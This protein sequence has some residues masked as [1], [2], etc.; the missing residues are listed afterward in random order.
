MAT[1]TV[2]LICR[3]LLSILL[4]CTLVPSGVA[5]PVNVSLRFSNFD[6]DDGLSQNS[7]SSI[8]QDKYG[9]IWL[10]TQGGINRFDGYQ[11]THFDHKPDDPGSLSDS[12][13]LSLFVDGQGNLWV[14]THSGGLN[15]FDYQSQTFIQYMDNAD[16][17]HGINGNRI[18]AISQSHSDEL[19]IATFGSGL[20]R[21]DI[22]EQRFL[23]V[24]MPQGFEKIRQVND[25]VSDTQGNLWL[26]TNQYGLVRLSGDG[27]R[28]QAFVFDPQDDTSFSHKN[29]TAV[30][31]D[32]ND[33]LWAGSENGLNRFDEQC[34]CFTRYFYQPHRTGDASSGVINEIVEDTKGR[35]WLG[36]NDGL[37]VL[38]LQDGTTETFKKVLGEKH[39]LSSNLIK[40]LYL[41]KDNML[42]LGHFITG[43]S[44]LNLNAEQFHH[45]RKQL[46]GEHSLS[47][48]SIWRFLE[49]ENGDIW[50]ATDGGGIS[51][52]D[53]STEQFEN[54]VAEPDNPNSLSSNYVWSLAEM[55]AG[56]IWAGTLDGGLNR[57]DT[58]SGEFT[59]FKHN[60][61]PDSLSHNHVISLAHDSQGRF[62][63]GTADGLELFD[64]Q[65][66]GFTHFRNDPAKADSLCGNW[67][68]A[69]YEDMT[70]TIWL[71]TAG[72]GTCY[73]DE[74]TKGFV[75]MKFDPSQP[76]SPATDVIPYVMQDS[77]GNIWAMTYGAGIAR[78]N[79]GSGYFHRLTANDGLADDSTLG[80]VEDALGNLWVTTNN[81]LS[82]LEHDS[83]RFVNFGVNDGL[84]SNE[85]NSGAH[86]KT[87]DN[88]LF[89]GGINGFN[90]FYPQSIDKF[91]KP[92]KVR[93]TG[94]RL[95]NAPVAVGAKSPDKGFVLTRPLYL[96]EHLSLNYK[97]SL[98]AFEF[99]A[100]TY[101][102]LDEIEYQ[103]LLEGFDEQ[104]I[105]A[106]NRLPMA[107]YTN[108]P[109]GSYVLK[110]RAKLRHQHWRDDVHQQL[111]L[112]ILPPP[113]RS[114]WA[115][116]LYGLAL[117][118]LAGF[119]LMQRHRRFLAVKEGEERLTLALWGSHSEFWD[120]DLVS[121]TIYRSNLFMSNSDLAGTSQF[122][123][124]Q[125]YRF[126]HPQDVERLIDGL[127]KHIRNESDIFDVTYRRLTAQG[128]WMWHRSRAQAVN[129]DAQGKAL[130]V[131]G[132]VTD[133]NKLVEVQTE[134]SA[135]NEQLEFRVAERTK[136]LTEALEQ[137]KS[138]QLQLVESEKMASLG[139]LVIGISHELNT[140]LGV[141][142]TASSMLRDLLERLNLKKSQKQLRVSDFDEFSN[143]AQCSLQLLD[144]NLAKAIE[145]VQ[146]FKSL[147]PKANASKR[148]TV[149]LKHWF[150]DLQLINSGLGGD[151]C[152]KLQCFGI[153]SLQLNTYIN[154]LT[155]LFRELMSNSYLH[156]FKGVVFPQITI[157]VSS[158]DGQLSLRYRDNG[159]GLSQDAAKKLFEPFFTSS[160]G[161]NC[162]GLGMTIVYNKVHYLFG[163]TLAV[164][165]AVSEGFALK[166][167]MAL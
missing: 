140:P 40:A 84:Q 36:T 43:G 98:I 124:A 34:D 47:N 9:F 89:F 52:F 131:V 156:G 151:N 120:W 127:D 71:S 42:W 144:N 77:N 133:V 3:F 38:S 30:F 164:D 117:L 6:I 162:T 28:A 18:M 14:G 119:I 148:T 161:S 109:P 50:I 33:Q 24:N 4:I 90:H 125:L 128:Q 91:D 111:S 54:F 69:I 113:W 31:I 94:M 37:K 53:R 74:Q 145:L 159:A 78:L 51:R 67:I 165:D 93:L 142:L 65:S 152:A 20:S 70:K 121:N 61:K 17:S 5:G 25:I 150:E 136:E 10:A 146:S 39:A 72:G 154:E 139:D 157:T 59:H 46:G 105:T 96:T 23:T 83:G 66:G 141:S 26:A 27:E 104:W 126:V 88:E 101:S 114:W 116:S 129:R 11:F 63:V 55:P 149:S 92:L 56:V 86:M 167:T 80:M 103:Y 158:E 15:R 8:V 21:F 16:D 48:N 7:I 13:V 73:F 110:L 106:D 153:P 58:N 44:K 134:L 87:R 22:K 1:G 76:D 29:A 60:N 118:L 99:S 35:L 130:R 102:H 49:A 132:T 135:I 2:D 82:K 57:F 166:M 97:E 108:V 100:L 81:G 115:Y 64:E 122:D 138:T 143:A 160:R 107:T 68:A 62:W 163:G 85:F 41:D 75:R 112:Q 12:Y 19:L 32:S 155:D 123:Y 95:F 45:H 147:S 137:L 79:V